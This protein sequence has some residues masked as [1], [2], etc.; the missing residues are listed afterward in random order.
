MTIFVSAASMF[1]APSVTMILA[2][3]PCSTSCSTTLMYV[4]PWCLAGDHRNL[5]RQSRARWF[6]Y[7]HT[8]QRMGGLGSERCERPP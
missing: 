4:L 1:L 6:V 5:N 3:S 8:K 7:L 2:D